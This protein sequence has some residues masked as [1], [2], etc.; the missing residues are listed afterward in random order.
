MTD[1]EKI[2]AEVER[3]KEEISIGLSAYDAGE[4]NGKWEL[5]EKILSFIN[6]LTEEPV[7]PCENC[8]G[9]GLAG[10][11]ASISELG[12]CP[13][14]YRKE[15]G[16]V[17]E[18][19]TLR[20]ASE[21]YLKVLSET[22]YNNTPI[23]NAQIIV[24]ELITFLDNPSKYNPNHIS[25]DLEKISNKYCINAESSY[26]NDMFDRGDIYKA[27]KAG[28]EWQKEQL[29]TDAVDGFVEE[30]V[31]FQWRIVSN[32]IEGEFVVKNKLTDGDKVK[33]IIV[34]ED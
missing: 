6:S 31:M 16:L 17:S 24:R 5:C 23:T 22:P 13:L 3:L 1:K 10:T 32:D 12:R 19:D 11:C 34:K 20:K 30:P 4:E 25:E 15:E 9:D 7:S 8:E 21:E 18:E 28:A 26:T 33:M 14:K 27:F 2:K 29:M